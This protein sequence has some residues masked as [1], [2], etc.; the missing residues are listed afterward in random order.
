MLAKFLCSSVRESF[1]KDVGSLV[2]MSKRGS[3]TPSSG[4][5]RVR[6]GHHV[7]PRL[8][9]SLYL[10]VP[11]TRVHSLHLLLGLGVRASATLGRPRV[12]NRPICLTPPLL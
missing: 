4:G 5:L 9:G 7:S 1:I 11:L 10:F 3:R 12:A 8:R 6:R 2:E